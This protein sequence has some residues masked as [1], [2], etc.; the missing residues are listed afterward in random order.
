MQQYIK[1]SQKY[2]ESIQK[3]YLFCS[4]ELPY[5][6]SERQLSFIHCIL[7][8]TLNIILKVIP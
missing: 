8:D 7:S 2:N 3:D 1:R 6:Y 5:I 4:L